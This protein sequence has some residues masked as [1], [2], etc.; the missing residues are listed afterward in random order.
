MT[1]DE[2]RRRRSL[3]HARISWSLSEWILP[4]K[5]RLAAA[6]DRNPTGHAHRRAHQPIHEQD[7][8]CRHPPPVAALPAI[9]SATCPAAG[10]APAFG[11]VGPMPPRARRLR[12]ISRPSK[13]ARRRAAA[14]P[15]RNDAC[16]AGTLCPVQARGSYLAPSARPA[17]RSFEDWLPALGHEADTR[18]FSFLEYYGPDF[19]PG[20]GLGTVEIW[21][22]AQGLNCAR[23]HGAV[24][25]PRHEHIVRRP[26]RPHPRTTRRGHRLRAALR[27]AWPDHGRRAGG[28]PAAC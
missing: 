20:T 21:V 14:R 5:S 10:Q 27:R 4:K 2:V 11:V 12:L 23:S 16:P 13:P 19:E 1:P 8:G 7:H 22:A 3:D 6:G 28:S 18:W 24:Y 15:D 17:R 26:R 9:S 25:I